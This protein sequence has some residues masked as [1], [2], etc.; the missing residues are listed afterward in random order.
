MQLVQAKDLAVIHTHTMSGY[1]VLIQ[2]YY[3][4]G[5]TAVFVGGPELSG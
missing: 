4:F 1:G 5:V 3:Y 2:Y